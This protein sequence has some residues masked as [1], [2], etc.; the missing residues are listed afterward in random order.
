MRSNPARYVDPDSGELTQ[1]GR[2][3]FQEAGFDPE[4]ISAGIAAQFA[5]RIPKTG[6]TV[7]T[8]RDVAAS[9]FNIPLT[10]GDAT[11]QFARQAFEQS[12]EANAK[13]QWAGD[14]ARGQREGQV[15]AVEAAKGDIANQLGP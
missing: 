15:S 7:S 8:A 1:R 14:I 12:A 4:A 13:G 5:A 9:E 10:R 2:M 6:P 3:I 11:Q